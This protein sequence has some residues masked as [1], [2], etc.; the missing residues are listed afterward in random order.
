MTVILSFLS[1]AWPFVL[2]GLGVLFGLLSHQNSKTTTARSAQREAEAESK[3]ARN[4]AAVAKANE[5]AAQAGADN[6]KVRRDEDS[7]A[8]AVPDAGRVLRDEGWTR[9]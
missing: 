2:G 8:A 6:Q 1:E 7:A 4:E 9:D 3:I 5:S